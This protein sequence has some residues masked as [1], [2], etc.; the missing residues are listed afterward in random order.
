M[1]EL[2]DLLERLGA[3]G[4]GF[5]YDGDVAAR[6]ERLGARARRPAHPTRTWP[7]TRW[8]SAAGPR[9]LPRPRRAHQP[10]AVVGGILI[11]YSLDLLERLG[12]PGDLR[13]LVEVMDTTNR[14]R[15]EEFVTGLHHE[16]YLER[17]LAKEAWESA[18]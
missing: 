13:A 7:P 18:A 4:P 14:A 10:A 15:T 12:R 17:F 11:A 2:G 5:L 9:P 6:G 1:P 16:G 3:E 8:W